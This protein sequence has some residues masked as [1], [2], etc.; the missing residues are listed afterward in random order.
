MKLPLNKRKRPYRRILYYWAILRRAGFEV[1]ESRLRNTELSAPK[2][3]LFNPGYRN[4]LREKAYQLADQPNI[5]PAPST[6]SELIRELVVIDNFR[7]DNPMDDTLFST[8]S[9]NP[10][11]EADDIAALEFLNPTGGRTTGTSILRPLTDYHHPSADD[12]I[13]E[14]LDGLDAKR[15]II[16]D[17]G[18]ATDSIRRYF[19]DMVSRA[20]F[21]HQER[22][23]TSDQLEDHFVQIY[24]EEAHNLFPRNSD[25]TDIYSRFAKEGA[26][27]HIGMVYST[28]SPSTVNKDLLAQTE[29]FFVGHLSSRDEANALSRL[30]V[31]FSGVEAD[32]MSS[33]TPGY[34]RMLTFSHRFVVPVYANLFSGNR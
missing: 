15:T 17:L 4:A 28:Q 13:N 29:N 7:Q 16:L 20:V 34:M 6:L 31:A 23:F 26:K 24:F 9:G 19:S 8:G 22:K 1:N 33:R 5:P 14:I 30:Q 21:Q 25:V 12:F 27:F 18:N 32:I 2:V 11:F 10:T 3:Q